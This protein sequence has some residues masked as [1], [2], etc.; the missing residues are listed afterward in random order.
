MNIERKT[1]RGGTCVPPHGRGGLSPELRA[2]APSPPA[3]VPLISFNIPLLRSSWIFLV[4][5][6]CSF[7]VPG[8]PR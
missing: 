1:E 7:Y 2:L 8:G 3:A 6:N 4:S 5:V